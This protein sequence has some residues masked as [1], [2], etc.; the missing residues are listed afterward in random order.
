MQQGGA[1]RCAV[2]VGLTQDQATT[3][4]VQRADPSTDL[5]PGWRGRRSRAQT[6]A[7]WPPSA[8]PTWT[9][10]LSGVWSQG[11]DADQAVA[12]VVMCKRLV[13]KQATTHLRCHARARTWRCEDAV[14]I[15]A[16]DVLLNA[17]LAQEGLHGHPAGVL[18]RAAQGERCQLTAAHRGTDC[19][20]AS[21][22]CVELANTQRSSAHL[23][24]E[25][26]HALQHVPDG[27]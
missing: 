11:D 27:V 12:D 22:A 18:L 13:R 15:V 3:V 4:T 23:A 1:A 17:A 10:G 20:G 5:P 6:R 2:A 7:P 25:Q 26:Q 24:H 9:P 16:Q 14:C 21:T 19:W 8:C